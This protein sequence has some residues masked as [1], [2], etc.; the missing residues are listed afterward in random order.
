V[1]RHNVVVEIGS[2]VVID[3]GGECGSKRRRLER[4][5]VARS[6]LSPTTGLLEIGVPN[7]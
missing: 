4:W 1:P 2:Q 6:R 7:N 3:C 5:I